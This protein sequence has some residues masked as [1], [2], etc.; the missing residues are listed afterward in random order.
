VPSAGGFGRSWW[1][2]ISQSFTTRAEV[3]ASAGGFSG[4][5]EVAS[6]PGNPGLL[7]EAGPIFSGVGLATS[8]SAVRN[9]AYLPS[10]RASGEH[11][12]PGDEMIVSTPTK[13]KPRRRARGLR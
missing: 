11:G 5:F 4:F 13:K 6:G 1:P 3:T 12:E 9:S 2:Q 7:T 8:R 10:S